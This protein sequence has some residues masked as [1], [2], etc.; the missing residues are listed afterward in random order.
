MTDLVIKGGRLLDGTGRPGTQADLAIDDGRVSAIGAGLTGARVLDAH[1]YAVSPGFIDIHRYYDAQVFWD[2]ALTPSCYHV[3]T[4]VVAGNCGFS[5][6]P[7]RAEHRDLILR[8]LENVEDM[9][10]PTLEA[11]VPW[12]FST[13]PEYLASVEGHGLGL[14]FAAYVGH[15]AIRLF[16]MGT[17]AYARAATVEE[18]TA[19]QHVVREAMGAGA[20]GFATSLSSTHRG[21]GRQARPGRFAGRAELEALLTALGETDRGVAAFTPGEQ[22]D[23]QDVYALQP[24]IAR[25]F[26]YTALMTMAE[27]RH[28]GMVDLNR[29]GWASGAEV[30]PQV[31]PPPSAIQHV[32]RPA[33][34][35]Q[36]QPTL[37]G[38]GRGAAGAP[39]CLCGPIVAGWRAGRMGGW[40]WF[41]PPQVGDLPNLRV[42]VEPCPC[43]AP[44]SRRRSGARGHA[45]RCRPRLSPG[46]TRPRA[47]SRLGPC[48][49][50]REG[51]AR[52]FGGAG[53][54]A[55]ALGCGG[56]REPGLR[57]SAGHGLPRQLGA[58]P[59]PRDFGEGNLP[60]RRSA[61][62]DF[63]I[64]RPGRLVPGT[65]ADVVVS[66][67][68]TIGRGPIRRVS[69][70]PTG[71]ERLTADAPTAVRHVLVNGVPIRTDGVQ[72]LSA[73]PRQIVR[74][75]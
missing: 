58:R 64:R 47:T 71:S 67:P 73:R 10:V 31:S 28:R 59:R 63:R 69:D 38:A 21:R 9:D 41:R 18:I 11:G 33:L 23:L 25:P 50:R 8:T 26:T 56:T 55:G 1:G 36:H 46:G 7:T 6:A 54:H 16:A 3:V 68:D 60:P 34:H 40:N 19:M 57:R 45:A 61:G 44:G 13:F 29:H 65:W 14:N 12:D 53:L 66:T 32:A 42:D 48:Q 4:T 70:F 72:D 75:C 15:T 27:Q 5:L 43:R 62:R 2:P 37:C 20:A 22:L 51:A 30:W 49:R 35:L 74:P 39:F 52:Y 17:D 24:T